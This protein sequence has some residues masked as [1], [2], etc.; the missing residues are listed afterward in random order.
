MKI[1]TNYTMK[2]RKYLSDYFIFVPLLLIS[3]LYIWFAISWLPSM[4]PF[5]INDVLCQALLYS[6]INTSFIFLISFAWIYCVLK[7]NKF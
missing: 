4:I 7:K 6:L 3:I 2:N 5:F 1:K